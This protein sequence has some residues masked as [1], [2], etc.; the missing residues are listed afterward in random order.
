MRLHLLV[1][2]F[3]L[4][5]A[6]TA[7]IAP[8][9]RTLEDGPHL[10]HQKDGSVVARWV[11]KNK[12]HEKKFA[13]GKPIVLP[14]FASYMGKELKLREHKPEKA[15]WKLPKKIFVISDIE[16]EYTTM[17]QFMLGNGVIDKAGKWA[18]G[19]GHMVCI[20]DMVDRGQQVTE[21]MLFLYRLADEAK[22]AGGHLHYVIGNHEVMMMGGDVRYTAQKYHDTARLFGLKTEQIVGVD[23]EI[24][25]WW[26]SLNTMTRLGP[27][28][29]VHAGV[30]P[31]LA[32]AKIDLD[33]FNDAMR[34]VFGTPPAKIRDRN[35]QI[36]T[37]GRPG[38]L[39]YRGYFEFYALDFG[40][41]PSVAQLD[42]ILKNL[43]A[44]TI[45]VGHTKVKKIAPMFGKRRVLPIDIPWTDPKKARG[46]VIEGK[47]I[48]VVDIKGTRKP[49]D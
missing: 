36:I 10:F 38:P 21:A 31:P 39:W 14:E 20:G 22:A 11:S 3:A 40:P 18:Y 5:A 30:S 45:I 41:V 12:V 34:S 47:D 1:T 48:H 33:K 43:G 46:I 49:L 44:K 42:T 32:P 9:E 37:W 35:L 8:V 13:K 4:C 27:Y 16:G 24:G 23:T 17:R 25:R 2:A 7:Q 15:V 29:F 26:R 6:T 19:K 28:L